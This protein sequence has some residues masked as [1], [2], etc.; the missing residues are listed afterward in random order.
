VSF[1]DHLAVFSFLDNVMYRARRDHI[2]GFVGSTRKSQFFSA[3]SE[4]PL[5]DVTSGSRRSNGEHRLT[6]AHC[7]L[8]ISLLA[9]RFYIAYMMQ[10]QARAFIRES[11]SRNARSASRISSRTVLS[12][13]QSSISETRKNIDRLTNEETSGRRRTEF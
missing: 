1:K 6:P 11:A 9:Y 2:F 5:H 3:A 8:F 12:Y 7:A 13:F 4:T 10:A